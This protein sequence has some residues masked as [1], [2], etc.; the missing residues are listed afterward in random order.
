MITMA[1]DQGIRVLVVD[2]SPTFL[3][4]IKDIL[5]KFK[6]IDELCFVSSG[7]EAIEKTRT[8]QPQL[9]F[10]D[11]MMPGIGGLEAL[12]KIRERDNNVDVV[13]ISGAAEDAA[14]LTIEAIRQGALDFVC[15][16]VTKSLEEMED[17]FLARLS[18]FIRRAAYR[19]ICLDP[20]DKLVPV[21]QSQIPNGVPPLTKSFNDDVKLVVVGVSTGAPN[22]LPSLVSKLPVDLAAPVLA[23]V[24]VPKIFLRFLGRLLLTSSSIA[25]AEAADGDRLSPARILVAPSTSSIKV[26]LSG[27]TL[28]LELGETKDQEMLLDKLLYSVADALPT[29]CLTAIMSGFGEDGCAGVERL[30]NTGEHYCLV[31]SP[32]SCTAPERPSRVIE[33][34]LADEVV[35]LENLGSRIVK[36]VNK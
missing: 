10:M 20:Q 32:E 34:G 9:I 26:K 28:I 36:I 23:L 11:L 35:S 16:P 2:D 5:R 8:F 21:K 18:P 33:Q 15:K 24:D 3:A 1:N 12:A 30:R 19:R 29:G 25:I 6:S 7:M 17:Y 27:A 13:I 4:I 22:S 31:Q 14:Q